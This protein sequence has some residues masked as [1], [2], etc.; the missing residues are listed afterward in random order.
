MQLPESEELDISALSGV[1]KDT[2]NSY[3][4]YWI[5]AILDGL[6]EN[7]ESVIT[8][9]ELA[10]RMLANV[11]YPLDFYKLSFGP[12]DGFRKIAGYISNKVQIDN[13]PNSP[14]L[15]NQINHSLSSKDLSE[16]AQEAKKLYR[17]VPYRFIRPFFNS[18]TKGIP[19]HQV[20]ATISR[21]CYEMFKS[22]PQRVLYRFVGDAI[23]LNPAW[24]TYFQKHQSILR[25]FVHWH[26]VKFVQKNNPNVIG[27]TE[28][29]EKPVMRD[30]KLANRFWKYY[31][32]EHS[33]LRCIY[34]GQLITNQNLSLDHFLPWSY[35]AHDHLW[36]ITP[37][38]ISVNSSKSNSIPSLER[39]FKSFS[40]MQYKAVRFY[41]DKQNE[42]LLEDY[43]YLF[44]TDLRSLSEEMFSKKLYTQLFP[45]FQ[46]AQ[47]MGF[48]YPFI[49]D[50]RG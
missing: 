1:F 11:W 15:L 24:V 28:K 47:N 26:L 6:K 16:L 3:K 14:S 37:T 50:S 9:Q 2:T 5:L 13:R 29:L 12:Q 17:W 40:A 36:N 31:L 10:L 19:D 23:E 7:G 43:S 38:T 32:N 4:F 27:L 46:I 44:K 30:L 33:D 34:S 25:G 20:N 48:A 42:K 22:H 8:Q 35:V 18:E 21:L 39:Y 41:L 49:Y 45:H